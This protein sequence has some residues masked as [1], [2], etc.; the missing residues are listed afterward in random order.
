MCIRD[1]LFIFRQ[2]SS[3][4]PASCS[5]RISSFPNVSRP[6]PCQW[7]NW[8]CTNGYVFLFQSQYCR[9]N[10]LGLFRF[11]I[12][13]CLAVRQWSSVFLLDTRRFGAGTK[14]LLPAQDLMERQL[15]T[16]IYT[17]LTTARLCPSASLSPLFW[18]P[19][20]W[21]WLSMRPWTTAYQPGIVLTGRESL[22]FLFLFISI[23]FFDY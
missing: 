13:T 5:L 2:T 7:N 21:W 19:L 1:S 8:I 4:S 15:S 11:T 3:S 9:Q 17:V 20:H 18:L 22:L 16:S 10:I 14:I 6:F 12:K 23:L